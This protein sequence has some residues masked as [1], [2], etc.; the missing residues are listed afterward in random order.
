[1]NDR[2][3]SISFHVCCPPPPSLAPGRGMTLL[4][5]GQA[6]PWGRPMI[7]STVRVSLTQT[8]RLSLSHILPM[9]KDHIMGQTGNIRTVQ[10][11][12]M[13]TPPHPGQQLGDAE[14]LTPYTRSPISTGKHKLTSKRPFTNEKWGPDPAHNCSSKA[15]ELISCFSPWDVLTAPC[16][17]MRKQA[18]GPEPMR[19]P[20][21]QRGCR[22]VHVQFPHHP[23]QGGFQKPQT[24][25]HF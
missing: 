21:R 19:W 14:L 4:L 2:K 3:K 20:C 13:N 5:A 25:R 9:S 18:E 6:Q 1:M 16:R 17:G 10:S 11:Q 7:T 22:L 12:M 24:H 8:R 23:T 15:Q